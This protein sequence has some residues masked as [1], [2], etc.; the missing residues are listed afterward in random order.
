MSIVRT[1]ATVHGFTYHFPLPD[2]M[3]TKRLVAIENILMTIAD[4]VKEQ[5]P[6]KEEIYITWSKEN[7][8]A[9]NG[10]PL[11]FISPTIAE[12]DILG[13]FDEFKA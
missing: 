4:Y 2:R 6:G 13:I 7:K 9:K 12:K 11:K 5:I 3:K 1:S 8:S 10:N